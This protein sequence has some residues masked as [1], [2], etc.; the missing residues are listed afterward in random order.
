MEPE[1]TWPKDD[2][3]RAF[4]EGAKWWEWY[5]SGGSMWNSDVTLSEQE[6]EKL[7]PG[8]KGRVTHG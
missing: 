4:V 6:A 5:S 7:Y 8:G 1:G 3:R 2:L